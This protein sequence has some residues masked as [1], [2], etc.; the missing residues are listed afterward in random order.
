[1][2]Q[3]NIS[4]TL[5]NDTSDATIAY[6]EQLFDRVV[7]WNSYHYIGSNGETVYPFKSKTN[8]EKFQSELNKVFLT[9]Y[10]AFQEFLNS[11]GIDGVIDTWKDVEE[12]LQ[13]ITDDDTMTLMKLIG[14]IQE[15]SGDLNIRFS[16]STPGVL[17]AVTRT[18]APYITQSYINP[19]TGAIMIIHTFDDSES[20]AKRDLANNFEYSSNTA[21]A[22]SKGTLV[23]AP[24]LVNNYDLPVDYTSSN[25]TV[26]TVNEEGV[27]T[28][29]A[30]GET[31]IS[32][33]FNGNREYRAK[34]TSFTL[35]VALPINVADYVTGAPI[36]TE[37]PEFKAVIVDNEDKILWGRY[38][39]NSTTDID[40]SDDYLDGVSVVRIV[41]AIINEY[42]L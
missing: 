6:A 41:N 35:S 10:T 18:E 28:V 20:P 22:A 34:T 21:S 16:P 2:A 3:M 14:D 8:I 19:Q 39:D 30:D 38:E 4:N 1:M 32:A 17:Q 11:K 9:H 31:T 29:L 37:N 33:A 23:S 15:A 24:T 5:W 12:F 7:D 26:A 25:P 13:N 36:E 40:L 42:N 27:V